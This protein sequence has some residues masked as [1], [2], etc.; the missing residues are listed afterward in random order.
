MKVFIFGA[1]EVYSNNVISILLARGY[2]CELIDSNTIFGDRKYSSNVVKRFFQ[3]QMQIKL[4]FDKLESDPAE[5]IAQ[6]HYVS[7]SYLRYYLYLRKKFKKIILW[8]WG[9]DLYR[10][11][12]ILLKIMFPLFNSADKICFATDAMASDFFRFFPKLKY[13]DYRL[14]LGL[15]VLDIIDG[16]N[17]QDLDFFRNRLKIPENKKIVVVGYNARPEQQHI[18]VIDSLPSRILSDLFIIFPW[19]YGSTGIEYET[20]LLKSVKQKTINYIFIK[21][22]LSMKDIACLRCITDVFIHVQTTDALSG[23]MLESLYAG[24]NVITGSWLPYKIL[25]DLNI[26]MIKVNSPEEVGKVIDC[27][28]NVPLK[29]NEKESNRREIERLSKWKECLAPLILLYEK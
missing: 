26:K 13:K 14:R 7:P 1:N 21:D 18:K 10:Q 16:I 5:D 2:I 22:F 28:L 4:F 8:F 29:S 17:K 27:A 11:R 12:K 20:L 9:S 23:S 24:C 25:D 3:R 19:T 6:I 15:P